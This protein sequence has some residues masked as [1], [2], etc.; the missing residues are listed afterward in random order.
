LKTMTRK[1]KALNDEEAAPPRWSFWIL[2]FS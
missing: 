1:Q 2:K